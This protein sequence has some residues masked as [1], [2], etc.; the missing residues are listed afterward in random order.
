MGNGAIWSASKPKHVANLYVLQNQI[1]VGLNKHVYL[2]GDTGYVK[3]IDLKF[4]IKFEIPILHVVN[5]MPT[6]FQSKIL[7]PGLLAAT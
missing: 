4:K 5:T 3:P 1:S 6:N 2:Q 7:S